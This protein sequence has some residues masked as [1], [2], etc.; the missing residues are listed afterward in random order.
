MKTVSTQKD[1]KSLSITIYNNGY[2]V[3]KE[4][5]ALNL[6]KDIGHVQ[7][8]DVAEKIETNS[9]IVKGL[10]IL[11][12]NYDH[13]LVSKEKLLEK[14]L[15]RNVWIANKNDQTEYRLLSVASGMVL[16]NVETKEIV[17][18]PEGQ[19]IL[20]SLPD[21]LIVKP[22]LIWKI[23]PSESKSIHVSYITK[24]IEWTS[25]YVMNL[26]PTHLKLSGWVE[27]QNHS[28][29]TY[30][31][32]NLKLIAGEVKRVEQE[33]FYDEEDRL[34]V[35]SQI[36]EPYFEEK[37]FADYHMYTLQNQ[38]T[39]KQNQSKQINF[40]ELDQIPYKKYY[41][42]GGWKDN[43]RIL[44]EFNNDKESGMGIPLPKGVI[45]VY[46]EDNQDHHLEFIGEDAIS[47][48]PKNEK[49]RLCLGEAFDIKC[50]ATKM[51]VKKKGR[52]E[53]I[54]Y[55]FEVRNHK[56][57]S[58]LIKIP[59]YIS[60]DWEMVETSD[61]YEK[62]NANDIVFW[63][64]VEANTTKVINITYRIDRGIDVEVNKKG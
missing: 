63:T 18:N 53:Y 39:L 33:R 50:D 13:D 25:N 45:R 41:E 26:E 31:N 37:S 4:E 2:G 42:A 55:R 5:R 57:E 24:G 6:G 49:V 8:V 12:L 36:E 29:A 3:V 20:P 15:D 22:A 19:L 48:T 16:E 9:L 1:S 38:T 64:N 21:E 58:A 28:G 60:G 44:L 27:I 54:D 52:Y 46:Q 34:V 40:I 32:A 47:H 59:H 35:Y 14:Y 10:H 30:Q 7:F 23:R 61:P 51:N 11:E 17:I 56:D 62:Q 43:P